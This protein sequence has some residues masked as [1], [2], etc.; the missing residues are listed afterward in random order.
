MRACRIT[1][2]CVPLATN[3]SSKTCRSARSLLLARPA[4]RQPKRALRFPRSTS[5]ARAF[6]RSIPGLMPPRQLRWLPRNR[7][8]PR[9]RLRRLRLPTKPP[10]KPR[11]AQHNKMESAAAA[12]MQ[13]S[14]DPLK[15]ADASRLPQSDHFAAC[16]RLG[17]VF[18]AG[19]DH[20]LKRGLHD[21]LQ[22][23]LHFGGR[24]VIIS[25]VL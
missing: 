19:R 4:A 23:F 5:P 15:S 20:M 8:H 14:G 13:G 24:P 7:H 17:R 10:Q 22:L 25:F 6:T 16:R 18:V 9:Q 11:E 21:R 3:A 12:K 2:F 1:T